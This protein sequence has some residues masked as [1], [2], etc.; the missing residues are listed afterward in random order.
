MLRHIFNT[1]LEESNAPQ[2]VKT[3][4]RKLMK[5]S[6]EMGET[7]YNHGINDRHAAP[8]IKYM[9]GMITKAFESD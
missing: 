2:D 1:H 8:A 9:K 7:K 3:S 4:S 5:Q 6:N